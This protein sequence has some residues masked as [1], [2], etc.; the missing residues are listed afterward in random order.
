[1]DSKIFKILYN[2]QMEST[3]TLIIARNNFNIHHQCFLMEL[4]SNETVKCNFKFYMNYFEINSIQNNKQHS[5]QSKNSKFHCIVYVYIACGKNVVHFMFGC[6][7][8]GCFQDTYQNWG[9]HSATTYVLYVFKALVYA[10]KSCCEYVC[11]LF[12]AFER[13]WLVVSRVFALNVAVNDNYVIKSPENLSVVHFVNR[14]SLNKL[15]LLMW[16][17]FVINLHMNAFFLGNFTLES[18]SITKPKHWR[19]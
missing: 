10:E 12:H 15:K 4:F 18:F 19:H 1:M 17:V 8:Y 6:G 11:L 16:D 2:S 5:N 3:S 9:L 13:L 7:G 14:N